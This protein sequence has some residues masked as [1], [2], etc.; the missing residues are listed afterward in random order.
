MAQ[1]VVL[2][3][4]VHMGRGIGKILCSENKEDINE[5]PAG[6]GLGKVS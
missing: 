1:T 5:S 3:G 4:A 6:I 2:G